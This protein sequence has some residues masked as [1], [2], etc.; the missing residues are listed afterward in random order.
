MNR[1]PRSNE[2]DLETGRTATSAALARWMSESRWS[3]VRQI[4]R[5]PS[6]GA[7][8]H[9]HQKGGC[10]AKQIHPS[11]SLGSKFI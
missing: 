7:C 8:D 3:R 11:R 6:K 5:L 9:S 1:D 4:G 2:I 10:F